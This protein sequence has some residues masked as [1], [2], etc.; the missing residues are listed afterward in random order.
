MM[1]FIQKY[2]LLILVVA[3]LG[4][5]GLLVGCEKEEEKSPEEWTREGWQNFEAGDYLNAAAK[6]T[7]AI[8]KD[9]L[10]TEAYVG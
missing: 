1:V 2:R 7:K 9:P 5:L 3:L 8:N 4:I 10:Y 6:F